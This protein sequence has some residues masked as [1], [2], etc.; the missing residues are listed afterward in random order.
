[1][2]FVLNAQNV[3]EYL[4]DRGLCSPEEKANGTV[5]PITAKN[6]NLLLSFLDQRKL[7][8]KQEPHYQIGKTSGEFFKEWRIQEFFKSFVELDNLRASFSECLYFDSENSILAFNYLNDYRDLENFYSKEK[9]FP[10]EIAA[11]IGT[12]LAT[13]HR[14]TFNQ[15]QYCGFFTQYR[16]DELQSLLSWS[17]ELDQIGPE[18]FGQVPSDGIKFYVLYQRYDSLGEAVAHL[19]KSF[20]LCCL[21]HNDLKLN[22]ILFPL[23]WE[24]QVATSD[25]AQALSLRFIDWE[26][27][28]WGDPA[29]DLGSIITSYLGFWLTS[30]VVSKTLGIDEALRLAMI[31]LD[32]LQPSLLALTNAYLANFP[33]ILQRQPDFL[34]RTM[35]AAGLV[36]IQMV[37]SNLQHRKTF[38]N[39]GICMLQVAKTLLCRPA[40]AIPTIFGV[41]EVDLIN[42]NRTSVVQL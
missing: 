17:R 14:L 16:Q 15:Q 20:N 11:S 33:E 23:D 38:G 1:M 19:N 6:F 40:Q 22:N 35:Q 28:G 27:S 8:V 32:L 29:F 24:Q 5:E 39:V 26:R 31:P 7:L 30:L 10:A 37:R 12:I 41:E 13:I 34:Q 36:L 4:I 21:T 2:S 9:R 3:F 25:S 18:I 42:P